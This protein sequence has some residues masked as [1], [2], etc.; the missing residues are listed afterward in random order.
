MTKKLGRFGCL[1][2]YFCFIRWAPAALFRSALR[3]RLWLWQSD[4]QSDH[5]VWVRLKPQRVAFR[6][7]CQIYEH[8]RLWQI[9]ITIEVWLRPWE[10]WFRVRSDWPRQPFLLTEIS[11]HAKR[12]SRISRK[13]WF[14]SFCTREVRLIDEKIGEKEKKRI[15]RAIFFTFAHGGFDY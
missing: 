13:T 5:H 14:P 10:A 6:L 9:S 2:A 7:C 1:V 4:S 11:I 12:R 3:F 15:P 8:I